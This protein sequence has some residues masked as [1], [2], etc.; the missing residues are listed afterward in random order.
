[1]SNIENAKIE[2]ASIQIEDHGILTCM[3]FLKILGGSQGFGGYN[4]NS[5]LS[6]YLKRLFVVL[7]VQ[8][9]EDLAGKYVRVQSKDGLLVAIGHIV[10]DRWFN[11]GEELKRG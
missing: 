2:S 1:M 10:E 11:P 8:S 7:D 6:W 3:L 9:F 4:N 5:N